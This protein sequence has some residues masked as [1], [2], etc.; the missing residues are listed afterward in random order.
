MSFSPVCSPD[1]IVTVV[2]DLSKAKPDAFPSQTSLLDTTCKPKEVDGTR[3]LY[4]FAQQLSHKGH[5]FDMQQVHQ[6]FLML[7]FF[8]ET[9]EMLE[10]H[11]QT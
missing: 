11:L 7:Q 1:G 6:G 8:L 2:C 9:L 3:V 5:H 4:E 10:G